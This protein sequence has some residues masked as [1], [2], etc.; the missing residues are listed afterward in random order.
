MLTMS[1]TIDL[2]VRTRCP[3]TFKQWTLILCLIVLFNCLIGFLYRTERNCRV[4]FV[5]H[6]IWKRM[7]VWLMWLQKELE[8][9]KLRWTNGKVNKSCFPLFLFDEKRK[10]ERKERSKLRSNLLICDLPFRSFVADIHIHV[11]IG[12]T[13]HHT[14]VP[15][16]YYTI[17]YTK[18][19]NTNMIYI[20]YIQQKL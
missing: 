6:R 18:Y 20:I 10:M 5:R 1:S 9:V 2:I 19:S 15:T 12:T 7:M 11:C 17:Q 14:C 4:K 16:Q 3:H 13:M 8:K